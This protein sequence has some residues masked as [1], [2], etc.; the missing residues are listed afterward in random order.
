MDKVFITRKISADALEIL[1]SIANVEIW[2]EETPPQKDTLLSKMEGISGLLSLLTDPIDREVI[3]KGKNLKVI[4][5]MAVGFDNI[6]TKTATTNG[7][8]VG[9]TPGVLT[10]ATADHTWALLM[11][12]ARRI[13]EAHNEVHDGI[14]RPWG[15]DVLCGMDLSGSTLGIIGMG[16]IGK[17][18]ARRAK[19]FGM[20]ILYYDT[21]LQKDIEAE[22]GAIFS[23]MKNVFSQ[24]DILSLHVYLSETTK[25][26]VNAKTLALM[27]PTAILINTS[28][29]GVVDSIALTNA[30]LEKKI[31][32][33]G[34]DVFDP[35]P[36]PLNHILLQ[37][38][39][40]IITPHI[41]SAGKTTRQKMAQIA[42]QNL[43]NGLRGE[44]LLHCANPE[45]YSKSK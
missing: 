11:A 38:K 29:G 25:Q 42:V 5:Q 27:K 15:P 37:Q 30:I 21:S 17:A 18:V 24:S 23:D 10:E 19:G 7:I 28:R 3:V 39:N 2:P 6:D 45:V 36:I 9:H 20:R 32:A 26:L 13:V 8:P 44:P 14:W 12:V 1:T 16:R 43:I 33:A 41:A 40:V 22:T 34:L 35:E 31:A 4:S